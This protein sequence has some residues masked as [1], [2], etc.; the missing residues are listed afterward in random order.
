MS[1]ATAVREGEAA[2]FA[3]EN[4]AADKDIAAV[5]KAVTALENGMAGAFLQTETAQIL[6]GVC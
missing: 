6:K 3:A 4:A 1:E 5:V 2:A